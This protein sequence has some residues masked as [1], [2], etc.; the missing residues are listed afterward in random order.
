VVL[1]GRQAI[2]CLAVTADV[3]IEIGGAELARPLLDP[4]CD[5]YD[6]VFSVPPFFWREDESQM[7][8]QRLLRLLDDP[9]FGITVAQND[10]ELVGFAYGF[11]LPPDT[12]RWSSLAEPA[13]PELTAEWLGRTFLLFDYAVAA[14]MRGRGIG[15]WLH[16]S[17]LGSRR[18]ERAT[19][20]VQP[21]AIDTKRIYEHWGWWQVGQVDG[22]PTA[23]APKFDVYLRDSLDDL[24]AAAHATP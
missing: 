23:A 15:R 19:L 20:T 17:L 7:H 22:G 9:T 14:P 2:G 12:K 13:E 4:I 11:S 5:L 24:R 6:Q 8:R 3:R 16:E 10:A 18:E 1:E 21:T